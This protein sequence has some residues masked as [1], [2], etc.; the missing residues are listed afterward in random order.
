MG[1]LCNVCEEGFSRRSKD[2]TCVPC[3]NYGQIEADFGMPVGWFVLLLCACAAATAAVLHPQKARLLRAKR[4]VYTNAK[5]ALGLA[6]VLSLLKDVLNLMFPPPAR[7]ALSFAAL[8]SA[9]VHA[10]VQFDCLGWSWF[11]T[12]RLT[13]LGLPCLGVG[14]VALRYTWQRRRSRGATTDDASSP[15]SNAVD[16]PPAPDRSDPPVL[17][18]ARLDPSP[19]EV[20]G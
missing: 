1:R 16:L 7:H 2:G 5:I 18:P 13:V 12:W 6:Q 17:A 14:L 3:T 19:S 20:L 8:L 15:E 10:L 9:D 4:A 11:D